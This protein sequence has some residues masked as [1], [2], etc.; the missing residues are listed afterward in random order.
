MNAITEWDISILEKIESLRCEPLTVF[1][2]IVTYLGNHGIIWI[3]LSLV[4]I[5]NKKTRRIG[6]FAAAALLLQF[7]CGEL[8]LKFIIQRERPFYYRPDFDTI[9]NHPTSYSFPSGH[10]GSSAAFSLAVFF[11]NKKLGAPLLLLAASICFSRIYFMVHY[12][13]DVMAGITLGIASAVV[14]FFLLNHIFKKK[15]WMPKAGQE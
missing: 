8:I 11:Q 12:P 9:I 3:L 5:I 14:T 10:S 15:N 7:I 4:L 2:R 1:F 13:T 6:L